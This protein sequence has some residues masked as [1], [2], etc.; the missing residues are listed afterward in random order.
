MPINEHMPLL[1]SD[2]QCYF[3]GCGLLIELDDDIDDLDESDCHSWWFDY[4]QTTLNDSLTEFTEEL[5]Q[6][7]L[8]TDTQ[9][10]DK[11][12]NAR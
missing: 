12:S 8:S 2:S 1:F 7:D 5:M 4:S 3:G 6:L 11:S 9:C 10:P